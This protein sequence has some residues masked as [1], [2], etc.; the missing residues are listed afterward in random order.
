MVGHIVARLCGIAD[1]PLHSGSAPPWLFRRMRMLGGSIAELLLK[2]LGQKEALRRLTD[3]FWFQCA[4]CVL[5]FDWHSSGTTTVTLA[6]LREGMDER[7]LP[8]HIF[9]GKGKYATS[10]KQQIS[11][12]DSEYAV[13]NSDVLLRKSREAARVDTVALQDGYDLYHHSIIFDEGGN[14]AVIQQGMN[15]GTHYARR[16]HWSSDELRSMVVEPHAA[17]LGTPG[18]GILNLTAADASE[19][20]DAIM[21]IITDDRAGKLPQIVLS[22]RRAQRTLDEFSVSAVRMLKMDT[23]AGWRRL[24]ENFRRIANAVPDSFEDLIMMEGVGRKTVLALAMASNLVYGAESNWRDPVKY[25]FAVGG[26]DGIP[27]PVDTRRMERMSEL[28]DQAV[29]ET[30]IGGEERRRALGRLSRFFDTALMSF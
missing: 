17:I 25:S 2:E 23:M 4:S 11:A 16:Y 3:P 28:L 10:M 5:G 14:W 1:L 26:K 19:A 30:E 21:D 20:R 18:S 13:A 27:Y 12:S 9:G 15:D 24:T 22:A 29:R 6:A 8:L 7:G